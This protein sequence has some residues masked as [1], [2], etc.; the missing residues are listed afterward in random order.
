MTIRLYRS[1]LRLYPAGYRATFGRF[2]GIEQ[3]FGRT[4]GVPRQV[5]S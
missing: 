2:G 5:Q 3:R 1:L 4:S